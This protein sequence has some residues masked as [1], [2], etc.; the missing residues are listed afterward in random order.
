M[1]GLECVRASCTL[2]RG[3]LDLF[4][5]ISEL[6]VAALFSGCGVYICCWLLQYGF[7]MVTAALLA[8][9]NFLFYLHHHVVRNSRWM[10][11]Y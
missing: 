10:V 3:A 7:S 11:E 5:I 9:L 6:C 1:S 8:C 2:G 4:C